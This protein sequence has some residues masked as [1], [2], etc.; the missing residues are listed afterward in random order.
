MAAPTL[1]Q[2]GA[3]LA[4][5][6]PNGQ[7]ASDSRRIKAGDVFF[8]YPG[9]VADGRNF[10]AAAINQ[11]AAA[12]LFDA[13]DF[14][15][16]PAWT[17]PHLAVV[18]LKQKAG[19]LAHAFYAQ[20]DA[21]MF[22]VGLTGTNGK[23]SCA[24][25]LGQALARVGVSTAVI[26]TLGVGLMAGVRTGSSASGSAPVAPVEF[27]I[28]GYTT[29][30]AVLLARTLADMRSAGAEAL[31]IEV[32]S[33]GLDQERVAGMHFDVALLTNLTRDHLDYHGDLVQYE[34]AK[35][36]LFD[37]PGLKCAVL[38]LDDA[39]GQRLA[40]HLAGKPE[41][42]LI[43]YTLA[44]SATR[45]DLDGGVT[46]RASAVR[47]RIRGTDFHVDCRFGS[48]LVKTGLVGHFN[49]SNALAVLAV[50]LSKGIPWRSAI[51][52]IEALTPA[53]GRMQ[54]VGG[55]EAPM[56][57]IDYA[58]TPDALAKTLAALRQVANERGGRLWCVF[59]C[60]GDRD[61]GKR[62]QMGEVAQLADQVLVTSDNP[63]S[64]D[65]HRIIEQIVAGMAAAGPQ[66]QTIEDRASAILSAIKHAAKLDVILLA[67]KGHEA[68]QEIRG[69]KLP[70]SDA[71][72]AALALAARATMMRPN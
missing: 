35:T 23:T 40:V 48:A 42:S 9:D 65:P 25:W 17:V 24:L 60:G 38:N 62:P 22:C 18:D 6:A 68:Y 32:S 8:A 7:L 5:T 52:A 41:L 70:F 33:I 55:Q 44:D 4:E 14:T 69:K 51:E 72:H 63:R 43:G 13:A 49:I 64:E 47:S 36:R 1:Q 11:G 54:Q 19:L 37:W 57:V 67:G 12:V 15:W 71:D 20:P 34:A 56:V 61:P 58:H 59:G 2:I 29:P 10:I 31:A 21:A 39:M 3:W 30:D 27:D 26:G 50:L 66:V 45:P 46:L 28:T 16:N 53:P